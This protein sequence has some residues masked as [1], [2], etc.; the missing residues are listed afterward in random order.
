MKFKIALLLMTLIM[1][2]AGFQ[3]KVI[4]RKRITAI[5]IEQGYTLMTTDSLIKYNHKNYL[6]K[7]IEEFN[8]DGK[9]TA[10]LFWKPLGYLE[11][12]EE[13]FSKLSHFLEDNDLPLKLDVTILD[14]SYIKVGTDTFKYHVHK[15]GDLYYQHKTNS[16]MLYVI[17]PGKG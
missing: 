2:V 1:G 14:N 10:V 17:S 4:V 8:N 6:V 9:I 15:S 3:K 5:K 12:K 11:F 16:K 13:E 7:T